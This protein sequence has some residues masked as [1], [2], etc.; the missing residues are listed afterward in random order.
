[1]TPKALQKAVATWLSDATVLV[2][3]NVVVGVVTPDLMVRIGKPYATV[4]LMP[5]REVGDDAYVNL[6]GGTHQVQ[7]LREARVSIQVY[8]DDAADVLAAARR[9]VSRPDL[10]RRA[11]ALGFEAV[12]VG[13]ILPLMRML[14]TGHEER[15]QAELL[16]RYTETEADTLAGEIAI[17]IAPGTLDPDAL[18]V[19]AEWDNT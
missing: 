13:P 9:G 2:P 10:I 14:D 18:S 8:G 4:T 16:A 1:M 3:G 5:E 17:A 19:Q 15:A 6:G 7:G 11:E 12:E